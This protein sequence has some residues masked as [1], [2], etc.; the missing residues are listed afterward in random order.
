MSQ[1]PQSRSRAA[2][3]QAQAQSREAQKRQSKAVAERR[4]LTRKQR[5]LQE[6]RRFL[7]I[8]GAV[9]GLTA[10]V[11]VAGVVYQQA[12]LPSRPV[13]QVGSATLTRSAYWQQA[14]LAIAQ[15]I[16][17]NLQLQNLF[18]SDPQFS[19]QFTGRSPALNQQVDLLQSQPENSEVL[20]RWID[21]QL[22]EQG[23]A[24]LGVSVSDDLVYQELAGT[25]STFLPATEPVTGTDSLTETLDSEATLP[26]PEAPP[27][28]PEAAAAR[29]QVGQ[30]VTSIYGS[31]VSELELTGV[32]PA[33]TEEDFRQA[34]LAQQR[35]QSLQAAVEAALVPEAAFSPSSEPERIQARQILIAVDLPENPSQGVIDAA[36]AQALA[37]AEDV[38]ERLNDGEEFAALAAEVSDDPGSAQQDGNVGSFDRAGV[39]DSGV[40]FAPE[41]VEAA[42]ALAEG[43]I[44]A[45]VRTQFGWHIIEVTDR[46]VPDREQQLATARREAFDAWL[47]EQRTSLNA[48]IL[49]EPTPSPTVEGGFDPATAPTPEPTFVPGPPTRP[50]LPETVPDSGAPLELE[51]PQETP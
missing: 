45:P 6:Q 47:E 49:P 25:Y 1:S 3:K 41:F 17:Q 30:I 35:R 27:P 18:G 43:E 48:R 26:T 11:L 37:E 14:R 13:A 9:L 22:V 19:Q 50:A 21:S 10:L 2:Q 8:I 16:A 20:N 28:T 51:L 12:W 39:S 44:S 32:E 29:D 15:E 33:L 4:H 7:M 36:Y 31:Y 40:T 46:P 42:F 24:S 23:A 38:R 5:E 34:L